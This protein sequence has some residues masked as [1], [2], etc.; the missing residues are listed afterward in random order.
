MVELTCFSFSL[1]ALVGAASLLRE[2]TGAKTLDLS[3]TFSSVSGQERVKVD[4]CVTALFLIPLF[5]IPNMMDQGPELD[6][7]ITEAAAS[8]KTPPHSTPKSAR[9][10]VPGAYSPGYIFCTQGSMPYVHFWTKG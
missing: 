4:V 6:L 2:D 7:Q 8:T 1:D 5:L 9:P 3:D 10:R